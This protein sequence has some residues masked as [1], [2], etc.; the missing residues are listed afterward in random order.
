[1]DFGYVPSPFWEQEVP[2]SNRGAPIVVV[3][4]I[5][6]A[7]DLLLTF[8]EPRKGAARTGKQEG[9]TS[10][11]EMGASKE[12]RVDRYDHRTD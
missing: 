4:P 2:G 6:A 3:V 9:L 12:L 1:M 7:P 8:D 11:L 10:H 5:L